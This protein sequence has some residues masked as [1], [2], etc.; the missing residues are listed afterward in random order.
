VV[1]KRSE[2]RGALP[3]MSLPVGEEWLALV[4]TPSQEGFEMIFEELP[5]LA[6]CPD[7]VMET[8]STSY[9]TAWR[10]SECCNATPWR[11]LEA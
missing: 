11:P 8:C 7:G 5:T 9:L 2:K 4:L 6:S 1:G 3:F 10:V